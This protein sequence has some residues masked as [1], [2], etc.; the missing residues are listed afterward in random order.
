MATLVP[1]G[2]ADQ[3]AQGPHTQMGG[4]ACA[5]G[6]GSIARGI[7]MRIALRPGIEDVATGVWNQQLEE[8]G[9]SRWR[10]GRLIVGQLLHCARCKFG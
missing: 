8:P 4:E 6:L 1:G 3:D 9:Q 5:A 7:G 10:H 2:F